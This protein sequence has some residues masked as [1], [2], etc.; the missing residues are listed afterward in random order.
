MKPTTEGIFNAIPD[1]IKQRY[2]ITLNGNWLHINKPMFVSILNPD[3][4]DCD[5]YFCHIYS[6]NGIV[7]LYVT[8]TEISISIS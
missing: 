6:E 3:L 1:K 8:Q 5:E 2:D 4:V 7:T